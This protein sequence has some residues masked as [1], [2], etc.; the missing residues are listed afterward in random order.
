MTSGFSCPKCK[1]MLTPAGEVECEGRTLPVYQCDECVV[2]WEVE[3]R[4]FDS[5]L[6]FAVDA[7]GNC[8]HPETLEPLAIGAPGDS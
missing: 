1:R 8:L 4:T 3:G 5:A 2:P 7:E 6:T